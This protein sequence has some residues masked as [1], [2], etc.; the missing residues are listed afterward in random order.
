MRGLFE[1]VLGVLRVG[2]GG[3]EGREREWGRD[4]GWGMKRDWGE[5]EGRRDEHEECERKMD[6]GFFFQ[7]KNGK[8]LKKNE[9]LDDICL[10]VHELS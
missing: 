8:G 7:R 10:I 3:R 5:M 2:G 4:R 9:C 6:L 1:G